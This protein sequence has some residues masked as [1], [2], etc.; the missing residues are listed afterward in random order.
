MA[1][2]LNIETATTV[3]SVALYKDEKLLGLQELFI[4]KSHSSY[5]A[6]LINDLINHTGR[7]LQDLDAIAIS[8]GPGSYTGLR[9]GTS[10][11]KGL[12]YSLDIP[13]IGINTL[14]AMAISLTSFYEAPFLC[15]M[16]DARRMEVYFMIMDTNRKVI[17]P[18]QPMIIEENSLSEILKNKKVIFFGNGSTKCKPILSKHSNAVFVD[19]IYPTAKSIGIIALEKFRSGVFE[20]L[21]Y[22]EPFYLKEFLATKAKKLL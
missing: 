9:I 22:F 7:K 21:A 14:E 6:T 10:S 16:I 1:L 18:T 3:C 11:A 12:C 13:L 8:K 15:P 4:D 5:L 2:I 20:D 19:S 17:E